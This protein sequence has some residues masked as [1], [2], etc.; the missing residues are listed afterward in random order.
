MPRGSST[1]PMTLRRTVYQPDAPTLA[2]ACLLTRPRHTPQKLRRRWP[3]A[4]PASLLK[5]AGLRPDLPPVRHFARCACSSHLSHD[6]YGN[7]QHK[8]KWLPLQQHTRYISMQFPV[9]VGAAGWHVYWAGEDSG[10]DRTQRDQ[11]RWLVQGEFKMRLLRLCPGKY[12]ACCQ[13]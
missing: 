11:P 13:V 9:E 2:S 7:S 6:T 10:R 4:I 1:L 3:T 5:L 8:D 12:E